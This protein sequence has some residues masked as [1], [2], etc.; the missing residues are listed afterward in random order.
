MS[1]GME[2]ILV[3][4]IGNVVMSDDGVGVRA[5]QRLAAGYRFPESV[6]L[7]DGGTLGLDLLPRLEGVERLLVIDAIDA[8]K[9]PGTLLRLAGE[10]VP[11]TLQT[12]LSPHQMGL[13]DLLAV[14]SLQGASPAEMTLLGVQ[15]ERIELGLELSPGVA[16]AL[17]SLVQNVLLE[18]KRWGVEGEV[19]PS[20]DGDQSVRGRY[21]C[22]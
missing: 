14:A 7:L 1:L 6:E 17:D 2:K 20:E 16:A 15:P 8:G 18:L 19:T 4:G 9:A 11:M 5:V 12:K 22:P 10:E 13:K 3:L 21:W